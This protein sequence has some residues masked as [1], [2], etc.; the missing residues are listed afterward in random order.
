M[1]ASCKH[2]NGYWKIT[3]EDVIVPSYFVIEPTRVD[4]FDVAAFNL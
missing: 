3:A 4:Y 2:S 1:I